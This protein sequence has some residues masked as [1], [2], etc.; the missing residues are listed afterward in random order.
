M[1]AAWLILHRTDW[2]GIERTTDNPWN[3][4]QTKNWKRIT[5]R[6]ETGK[7]TLSHYRLT[8]AYVN[9]RYMVRLFEAFLYFIQIIFLSTHVTPLRIENYLNVNVLRF[10]T[11]FNQRQKKNQHRLP[12]NESVD[13]SGISSGP[14]GQS[15][16]CMPS[17]WLQ[18]NCEASW[19]S[20]LMVTRDILVSWTIILKGR[21]LPKCSAAQNTIIYNMTALIKTSHKIFIQEL[22]PNLDCMPCEIR[23]FVSGSSLTL[24]KWIQ[25]IIG[26]CGTFT[27]TNAYPPN[28]LE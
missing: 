28:L 1:T 16:R 8:P 26:L 9:R 3:V 13:G 25:A 14:G 21:W 27:L 24:P 10:E 18:V 7:Y 17:Y 4:L 23:T 11:H 5:R 12:L 15:S 20:K 19:F 6:L 22:I 2:T